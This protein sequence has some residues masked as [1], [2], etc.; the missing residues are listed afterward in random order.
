MYAETTGPVPALADLQVR[1]IMNVGAKRVSSYTYAIAW[2][3][4]QIILYLLAPLA[5]LFAQS[6]L[7]Y[8]AIRAYLHLKKS[9]SYK[10]RSK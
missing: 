2:F 6:V 8:R 4:G 5:I 10:R 7:I 3:Y 9:D 1:L